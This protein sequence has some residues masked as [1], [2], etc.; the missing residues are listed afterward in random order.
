MS[1]FRWLLLGSVAGYALVMFTNPIRASL[2]DGVRA[3]RRYPSLWAILGFCGFGYALFYLAARVWLAAMQPA[4]VSPFTWT[5]SPPRWDATWLYGT[6]T[7]LF[8]LPPHALARA[9]REAWLPA[10][11]S[12]AGLFNNL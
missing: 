6:E 2:S 7:S 12:T 8:Y 5:R 11:E 4:E 10:I 1:P 9:M 3:L